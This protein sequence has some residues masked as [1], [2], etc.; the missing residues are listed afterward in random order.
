[1]QMPI[2]NTFPFLVF[3]SFG[4]DLRQKISSKAT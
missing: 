3:A 4:L 1:M 2:E